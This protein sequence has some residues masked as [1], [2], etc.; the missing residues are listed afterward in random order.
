MINHQC[1]NKVLRNI[2]ASHTIPG[3]ATHPSSAQL[4]TNLIMMLPVPHAQVLLSWLP[5]GALES[6]QAR[7]QG[8]SSTA[9]A[10]DPAA[11]A[12]IAQV[13]QLGG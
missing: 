13:Q 3:F 4:R 2:P 7:L 10:A 5:G 9:A 12:A 1:A 6:T 8:S 11:G